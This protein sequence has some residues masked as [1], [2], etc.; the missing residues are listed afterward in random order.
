MNFLLYS[1]LTR[2]T[3]EALAAALEIRGGMEM[4]EERVTN[5]IRW[6]NSSRVATNPKRTLNKRDAIELASNK[7]K[8]FDSFR[9]ANVVV[10]ATLAVNALT[11]EAKP[12]EAVLKTLAFPILAREEHHTRGRDILL[13]LQKKD[14]RRAIRWGKSI[15]VQYVPTAREY[16]VH[17]FGGEIIRVSQKVLMTREGYVPYLRNDDHNHTYRTPRTKLRKRDKEAAINAV[18]CLGLDFAAVDMIVGDDGNPYVLEVNT[19]PSL[20][21]IGVDAYV[22]KMRPFLAQE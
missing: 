12:D 21:E 20:I 22:A 2:R 13:C 9:E 6:G 18:A 19:G 4:P 11:Q 3:G 1:R 7:I 16:R 17:V 14:L 5:L 8:S 15:F 10:P